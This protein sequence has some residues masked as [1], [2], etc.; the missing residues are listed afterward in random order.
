MKRQGVVTGREC[1]SSPT[2]TRH[3]PTI[4]KATNMSGKRMARNTNENDTSFK[5]FNPD[6]WAR[7][8]G[9]ANEE[10]MIVNGNTVTALWDTGS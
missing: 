9:R 1:M 6:P 10:K 3:S 2:S 8:T 4:S 5:F 7:L